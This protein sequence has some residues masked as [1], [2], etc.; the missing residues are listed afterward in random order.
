MNSKQVY[1]SCIPL[2]KSGQT[3]QIKVE[4]TLADLLETSGPNQISLTIEGP[5]LKLTPDDIAGVYP[6]PG[7]EDSPDEFLPHIAL[8]RRTL[9]WERL[10]PDWQGAKSAP[11]LALLLLKESELRTAAQR[12]VSPAVALATVTLSQLNQPGD[13]K[14]SATYQK[15]RNDLGLANSTE[16]QVVF[17]P[18]ATLQKIRPIEDELKWLCHVKRK[19]ENSV[20]TDTAIVVCNRLPDASGA[21]P[22]L[23]TAVLVSLEKRDDLYDPAKYT[24]ANLNKRTAFIALHSWTFRA[25]QGGDFEQV[26]QAIGYRPNGGVLRFGNLPRPVAGGP[27]P[28][29]GGFDALL[30]DNG[31]LREEIPHTQPGAIEYRG[32][33]RPFPTPSRSHGLAVRAAPE[34]FEN[35]PPG[36][37]IDYSYAAAFELGRLLAL[38]D[39]TVLDQL[40]NIH[41]VHRIEPPVAINKLPIALQKPEWVVDPEFGADPGWTWVDQPWTLESQSLIKD[42]AA[43]IGPVEGDFTSIDEQIGVWKDVVLQQ[44]SALPAA[45]TPAVVQVN[46][47]TFNG[48]QLAQQFGDVKVAAKA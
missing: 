3:I 32:P 5:R 31:F 28:L 17:I 46:V 47:V 33:L 7:S 34:E 18:N 16:L 39:S 12:T 14:D 43:L 1:S 20:H 10:G 25:S 35:A 21:E 30:E 41:A 23:H 24:G 11:W 48:E 26:M 44:L 19:T 27:A 40:R 15:L 4:Q 45:S 6:A 42:E 9:P 2:E 29:F 8:K 38:A 13:F 37:P 36:A 22:E